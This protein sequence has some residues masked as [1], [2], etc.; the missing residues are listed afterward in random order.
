VRAF[1][2]HH[3]GQ[4]LNGKINVMMIA[5]NKFLRSGLQKFL[6]GEEGLVTVEWVALAVAVVVG[7]ITLAWL[8][9]NNLKAPANLIGKGINTAANSTS[10]QTSP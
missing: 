3:D 10:S 5:I 2:T 8:V 9:M 7:G 4:T 6:K 1:G